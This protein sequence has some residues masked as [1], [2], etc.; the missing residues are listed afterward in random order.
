M[1]R[2]PVA[3]LGWLRSQNN[4]QG[5]ILVT[6]GAESGFDGLYWHI[7]TGSNAGAPLNVVTDLFTQGESDVRIRVEDIPLTPGL[8]HV[9]TN[10]AELLDFE[11]VA[12]GDIDD[13]GRSGV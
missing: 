7:V 9:T 13:V 1:S 3:I 4:S 2:T 10:R 8:A 5:V 11:I 12:A 6:G